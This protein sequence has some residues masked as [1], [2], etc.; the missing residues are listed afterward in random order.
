MLLY[1]VIIM[2]IT[3]ARQF[4]SGGRV[5][6]ELA[7][8]KLGIGF[9]DKELINLAAQNSGVSPDFIEKYEEK[10]SSS[11][12]YSLSLGASAT[13]ST[14]YGAS[15]ELPVNDKVFLMQHDIIKK[16][17]EN[18]CVIVGR[19]A[20]YILSER[21][22]LIR[23]FIYSDFEK[24]CDRISSIQGISPE[25]AAPIIK[26]ADKVRSNYYS[27][28]ASGKWGD[29]ESYDLCINSGSLGIENS[30]ELI[31]EYAA[32]RGLLEQENPQ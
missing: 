32:L 5:I 13:I 21:S 28:F 30:A 26:K 20:D 14:E 23:V 2:I 12:L 7:A 17:S 22:D 3:I 15:P 24:R 31:L 27:R 10:A 4:G 1:E 18:P 6:G 11:L 29:P 19:C 8:N 9:Y 16:I 25:K